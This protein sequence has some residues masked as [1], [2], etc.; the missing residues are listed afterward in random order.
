[1]S[2]KQIVARCQQI[3][4]HAWMVRTFIKHSEEVDDFP[5]LMHLARTIFDMSRALETRVGDPPAYVHMLRKKIARLKS[6]AA[7]FREDSVEASTHTNFRQAVISIDSCVEQL[8]D[9]LESATEA[10][11]S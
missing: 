3:L 2:S 8:S 11:A 9:I 1:M 7:R 4:A 5:E 10:S 6:A